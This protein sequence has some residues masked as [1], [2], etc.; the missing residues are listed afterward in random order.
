VGN[1]SGMVC[2]VGGHSG[3][4]LALLGCCRDSFSSTFLPW[5][6]CWGRMREKRGGMVQGN[7]MSSARCSVHGR[8]R[9]WVSRWDDQSRVTTSDCVCETVTL[10]LDPYK[11]AARQNLGTVVMPHTWH[12]ASESQ[13]RMLD[14][15]LKLNWCAHVAHR[16]CIVFKALR[17][18]RTLL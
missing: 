3:H 11:F 18:R 14:F 5:A 4:P 1:C 2:T 9:I 7:W 8:Q 15:N 13:S 17:Y 16:S 6:S 12:S 10:L